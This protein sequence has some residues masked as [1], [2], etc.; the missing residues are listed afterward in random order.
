MKRQAS[1]HTKGRRENSGRLWKSKD[2]G[3]NRAEVRCLNIGICST[4]G[5]ERLT[6]V[7]GQTKALD[8]PA[9]SDAVLPIWGY[10]NLHSAPS[11]TSFTNWS[12][13]DPHSAIPD[14]SKLC[15]RNTVSSSFIKKWINKTK[16]QHL[17]YTREFIY[18]CT[19]QHLWFWLLLTCLPPSITTM[20]MY[21]G[22]AFL[23]NPCTNKSF[24]TADTFILSLVL[25]DKST[26]MLDKKLFYCLYL[27]LHCFC[28]KGILILQVFWKTIWPVRTAATA[29]V[30]PL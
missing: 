25:E 9:S 17:H 2:N 8:W 28:L 5:E 18:V 3:Q 11:L 4:P 22:K 16:L 10:R 6:F 13:R 12:P 15:G 27:L 20:G 24:C 14:V 7:E 21:H 30:S 19:L 26:Q 29:H 23:L 1:R